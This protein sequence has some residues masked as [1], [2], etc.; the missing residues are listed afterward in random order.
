MY[1]NRLL[2]TSSAWESLFGPLQIL[3]LLSKKVDWPSPEHGE[4]LCNDE[5]SC[6][7]CLTTAIS[8]QIK[9]LC[10]DILHITSGWR[11]STPGLNL[12]SFVDVVQTLVLA[13]RQADQD[14]RFQASSLFS[15]LEEWLKVLSDFAQ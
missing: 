15:S 11:I 14:D 6:F 1:A 2:W 9:T 10:I 8:G 7:I 5:S 13:G 12:P 4:L 3:R